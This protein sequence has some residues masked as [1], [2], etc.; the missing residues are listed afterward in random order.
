MQHLLANK[1]RCSS[2]SSWYFILKML[3]DP[4]IRSAST[5]QSWES[6]LESESEQPRA[7]RG[8]GSGDAIPHVWHGHDHDHHMSVVHSDGLQ[9]ISP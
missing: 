1:P 9:D 5:A 7:I 3:N 4:A 2:D 6:L 8:D